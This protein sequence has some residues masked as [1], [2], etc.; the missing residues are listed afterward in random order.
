VQH[1]ELAA[2]AL[3]QPQQGVVRHWKRVLRLRE[4]RGRPRL[5]LLLLLRA[6]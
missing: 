4:P 3:L 5:L 6:R 2:A 1:A